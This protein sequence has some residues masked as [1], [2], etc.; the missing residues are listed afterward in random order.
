MGSIVPVC[1]AILD[2]KLLKGLP[3]IGHWVQQ[4]S[5]A[6]LCAIFASLVACSFI[7]R[8]LSTIYSAK[9]VYDTGKYFA[10]TNFDVLLDSPY[11]DYSSTKIN[12]ISTLI[13]NKSN[14]M[15]KGV[16]N[17]YAVIINSVLL[18]LA[19]I[20]MVTATASDIGLLVCIII[21]G[22]Y[23]SIARL[24][25]GN[26]ASISA[27]I[28]RY[29]VRNMEL[30]YQ[31]F[32]A[33]K[34][35]LLNEMQNRFR[36]DFAASENHLNSARRK[37]QILSEFPKALIETA[38]ILGVVAFLFFWA[39]ELDS[40]NSLFE[41][42]PGL[43]FLLV[44]VQ[45]TL[46]LFQRI[47]SSWASIQ[48]NRAVA[49]DVLA[50][51]SKGVAL[52]DR[53]RWKGGENEVAQSDRPC[54]ISPGA[55]ITLEKVCFAYAQGSP[56][57]KDYSVRFRGS[58]FNVLT[59]PSGS[60]KSTVMD[61]LLGLLEPESGEIFVGEAPLGAEGNLNRWRKMVAHVPQ[62]PFLLD[63]T[64]EENLLFGE[65]AGAKID[66]DLAARVLT[67][68]GLIT[69]RP[70]LPDLLSWDIGA[71][72]IALSGG[73][74]QRLAISRELYKRADWLI[75]DEPTS[76][77]DEDS[78]LEV[79]NRVREHFPS[80]SILCI[81]HSGQLSRVADYSHFIDKYDCVR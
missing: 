44:A 61:L 26:L 79:I 20:V 28:S 77:L 23:F 36:G 39:R 81:S 65:P 73:Q 42:I 58:A 10:L 15:S 35:I 57:L 14:M 12:E 75:L 3:L 40:P 49:E 32:S 29:S 47:F 68:T 37:K 60:G 54:S 66:L 70:N 25:K 18:S 31:G 1:T 22:I 19:Y 4:Q 9:V 13:T 5:L 59:G 41:E 38:F 62:S 33:F 72:G 50:G 43:L 46:P 17:S 11:V 64:L 2:P 21:G 48:S 51:L 67:S 27:D 78:E 24:V 52:R 63:G 30:V 71:F 55:D 53:M 56:V 16:I 7:V 74:R 69:L 34:D 45:R 8:I 76:A 80:I 6:V